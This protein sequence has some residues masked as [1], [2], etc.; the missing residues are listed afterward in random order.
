MTMVAAAVVASIII[1]YTSGQTVVYMLCNFPYTVYFFIIS[2]TTSPWRRY[3]EI[4]NRKRDVRRRTTKQIK[5]QDNCGLFFI[6]LNL[7]VSPV[8]VFSFKCTSMVIPM[9]ASGPHT[10]SRPITRLGIRLT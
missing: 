6:V 8:S 10:I 7:S 4:G 9:G 3:T 5:I 1:L 2:F